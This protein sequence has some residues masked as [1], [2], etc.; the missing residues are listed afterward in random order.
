M[1]RNAFGGSVG[2][3][4]HVTSM[5]FAGSAKPSAHSRPPL[6][7]RNNRSVLNVV[8]SS[9]STNGRMPSADWP[10]PSKKIESRSCRITLWP[11]AS[12]RWIR[13]PGSLY[14]SSLDMSQ[15]SRAICRRACRG[16]SGTCASSGG[17]RRIRGATRSTAAPPVE[18]AKRCSVRA[19]SVA[20]AENSALCVITLSRF[21]TVFFQSP[22]SSASAQM[23]VAG[24][25]GRHSKSRG[26]VGTPAIGTRSATSSFASTAAV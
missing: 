19:S 22:P 5:W 24:S 14:F 16:S 26:P 9:V 17:C 8:R 4:C 7:L 2:D 21:G 3:W 23:S 15:S 25:V 11:L 6:S 12:V 1:R 20:G 18:A 10:S 13:L